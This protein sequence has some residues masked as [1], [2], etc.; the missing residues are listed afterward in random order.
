MFA[1]SKYQVQKLDMGALSYEVKKIAS[2]LHEIQWR[3]LHSPAQ[4]FKHFLKVH[5]KNVKQIH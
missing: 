1:M 3:T 5:L 4:M 2:V